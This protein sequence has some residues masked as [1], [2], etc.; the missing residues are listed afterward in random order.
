MDHIA[1]ESRLVNNVSVYPVDILPD[2]TPD[3]FRSGMTAS[4]TF[5]VAD[6]SHVLLIPSEAVAE[7]PKDYPRPEGASLA[8]YRKG[9]GGKPAPTPIRIGESDGRMT[10]VV[11]GLTEGEEVLVMRRRESARNKN[12]FSMNRRPPEQR[13]R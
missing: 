4:V 13:T 7:W 9:P 5:V 1:Y 6:R 2:E 3:T 10:E 12:P 11:E 8:A